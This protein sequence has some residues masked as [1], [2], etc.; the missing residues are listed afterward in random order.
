MIQYGMFVSHLTIL[1]PTPIL[2]LACHLFHNPGILTTVPDDCS[3]W[4]PAV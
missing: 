2:E 1:L 4:D 3:D